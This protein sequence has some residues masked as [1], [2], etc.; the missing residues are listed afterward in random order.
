M[1]GLPG[2]R[3]GVWACVEG[4]K[5][6]VMEDGLGLGLGYTVQHTDDVS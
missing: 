5:G 6:L 1:R 4:A 2:K 3:V